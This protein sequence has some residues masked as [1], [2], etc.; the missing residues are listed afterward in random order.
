LPAARS[1][2]NLCPTK[3]DE[4]DGMARGFLVVG[5]SVAIT[6]SLGLF[7]HRGST[8]SPTTVRPTSQEGI[9][10]FEQIAQ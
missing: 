2:G 10:A 4:E 6:A 7:A 9:A 8:Q 1:L 3:Y 5:I